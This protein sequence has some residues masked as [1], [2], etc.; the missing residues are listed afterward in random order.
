LESEIGVVIGRG[1][2]DIPLE[3]AMKSVAGYTIIND[4][5]ARD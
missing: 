3:D 4:L 1:G 5:S 2:E